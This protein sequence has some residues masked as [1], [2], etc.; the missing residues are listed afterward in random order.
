WVACSPDGCPLRLVDLVVANTIIPGR[1]GHP[2]PVQPKITPLLADLGLS[3]LPRPR[4]RFAALEE[5]RQRAEL[6]EP[7]SLTVRELIKMWGLEDRDRT[8][9]AQIDADLANHGLTTQPDYRAVSLDRTIRMITLPDRDGEHSPSEPP[10]RESPSVRAESEDSVDI[11]LTLGNLLSDDNP[12]VWVSPSATFEDAITAMQINDYSQ[13]AV[14]TNPR[15]LHGAVSWK[16][17]AEARH[18]RSDA[19]FSDA[20]D[21]SARS[22]VFDYD[23]RLLDV[24]DP[25]RQDDFIFVRDFDHKITGII[26]AADVV[27]KYNETATPFFLIGEIDQELRQLLQN[28]FDEDVIRQACKSAGLS[29]MSVEG[30]SIGHYQAVLDNPVCWKVLG[31]PLSRK[32]FISRLNEIRAVRNNVMHFNPDPPKDSDV[33]KL[34]HFLNLIRRYRK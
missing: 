21:R 16:S 17:I 18:L 30:M 2:S 1:E 33:D 15:T 34:R 19:N 13:V 23:T 9:S 8:A 29:F 7:E 26:T 6:D 10:S 14:L 22:R 3:R 27:H 11:G 31:W 24:L 28:T 5:A 32:L 12:L 20:I 4:Q 25:L